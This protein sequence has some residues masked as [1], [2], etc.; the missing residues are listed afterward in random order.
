VSRCLIPGYPG[1]A[2]DCRSS[3]KTKKHG[4]MRIRRLHWKARS[5]SAALIWVPTQWAANLPATLRMSSLDLT[6]HRA[7]A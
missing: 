5:C 3:L 6:G 4:Q 1:A 7:Y 2:S